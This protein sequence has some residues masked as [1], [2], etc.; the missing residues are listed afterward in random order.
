[1]LD[2]GADISVSC[3]TWTVFKDSVNGDNEDVSVLTDCNERLCPTLAGAVP[4]LSE[5]CCLRPP[6]DTPRLPD[7]LGASAYSA[8]SFLFWDFLE[9]SDEEPSDQWGDSAD[10]PDF[11]TFWDFLEDSDE[12]PSDQGGDSADCAEFLLIWDFLGDSDEE[13]SDQWGDSADCPDF[14]TFWDFLEDS[15]EGP[16]DQWGGS[17]VCAEFLLIWDFLEDFSEGLSDLWVNSTE[18]AE[19]L[20]SWDFIKDPAEC[21][22]DL[23]EL[24]G[25]LLC[26]IL[27]LFSSAEI[28]LEVRVLSVCCLGPPDLMVVS[29][30]AKCRSWYVFH[31]EMS[32]CVTWVITEGALSGSGT[33]RQ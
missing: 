28:C 25:V 4:L 13:P 24:V 31:G 19:S 27:L 33:C 16:S 29:S 2:T 26:S 11:L 30:V 6:V 23:R 14:L 15:D 8:D 21:P 7:I 10:C 9:D 5:L 3:T 12:G 32:C 20:L 17:A 18:S 22:S 1:M